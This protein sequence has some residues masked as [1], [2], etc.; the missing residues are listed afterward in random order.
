MLNTRVYKSIDFVDRK[1]DTT[2]YQNTGIGYDLNSKDV[3]K[4]KYRF[5]RHH[6]V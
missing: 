3:Y 1:V 2:G 5:H 4:N 6:E